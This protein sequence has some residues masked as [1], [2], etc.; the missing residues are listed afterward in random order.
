M[1]LYRFFTAPR[2]VACSL[3]LLTFAVAAQTGAEPVWERWLPAPLAAREALLNSPQTQMALSRRRALQAR[4][5]AIAAGSAE[6]S[7]RA[8]Q[9]QRRLP[10]TQERFAETT[11]ALERPVRAWG[12]AGLDADL[13]E[14]TRTLAVIEHADALH[15]ASRALIQR[16]FDHWRAL[17]DAQLSREQ[18]DLAQQLARQTEVRW[19]LGEVARLDVALAQA[20]AQRARAAHQQALAGVA[21]ARAVLA[22]G[23]PSLVL[24]QAWPRDADSPLPERVWH[25]DD[26]AQ[27]LALHHELRLLR[28]DAQR[29]QVSAERVTRE[30]WPDPSVGVFSSRER[31]GAERITGVML[32]LPLPGAARSAQAAAAH[33]DALAAQERVRWAEQQWSAQFDRVRAGLQ[34]RT[35]VAQALG[36]AARAQTDAAG[37][38]AKAYAL[39]EGSMTDL[40]QI[41]RVAAEQRR[42]AWRARLDAVEEG[43]LLELDLHRLWDWDDL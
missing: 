7:V 15:E 11:L 28:A 29:L 22:Y 32:S 23:Y 26:K 17:A 9:Q 14:Q 13:A 30:R 12:K 31:E 2:G 10:P 4:A 36:E 34:A 6:F 3:C 43:A 27:Y 37:K 35:Q 33:A 24:P 18:Q 20:D 39:G 40:I 42:G 19:R 16:W 38:A 21:Q 5:D 8:T 1:N 25:D 41:Q